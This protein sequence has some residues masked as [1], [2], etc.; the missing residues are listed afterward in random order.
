VKGN[1]LTVKMYKTVQHQL[2]VVGGREGSNRDRCFQGRGSTKVRSMGPEFLTRESV[3]MSEMKLRRKGSR[4][5][6][7]GTIEVVGEEQPDVVGRE[8]PPDQTKG[9]GGKEKN[10]TICNKKRKFWSSTR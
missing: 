9:G 3:L 1:E 5:E 7:Y 6:P 4:R 2:L 8:I 10:R